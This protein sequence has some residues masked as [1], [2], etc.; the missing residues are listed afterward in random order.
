MV[1]VRCCSCRKEVALS[2]AS[3][4]ISTFMPFLNSLSAHLISL[5]SQTADTLFRSFQPFI[6]LCPLLSYVSETFSLNSSFLPFRS[7]IFRRELVNF[8]SISTCIMRLWTDKACSG[9][10]A[11]AKKLIF[12][13]RTF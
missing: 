2:H 10:A 7:V 9:E 8:A 13:I 12:N 5:F 3:L 4:R 11:E 1:S 6:D